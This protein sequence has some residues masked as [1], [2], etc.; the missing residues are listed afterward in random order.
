MYRVI[1]VWY[2]V[3]HNVCSVTRLDQALP[4]LMEFYNQ[5]MSDYFG[6]TPTAREIRGLLIRAS[7]N[8]DW[9]PMRVVE[10]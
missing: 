8:R 5:C 4:K 2:E 1:V 3:E 6:N 7:G 9:I 10:E